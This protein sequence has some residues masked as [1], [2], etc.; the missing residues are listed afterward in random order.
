MNF[1]S[2][3]KFQILIFGLISGLLIGLSYCF[4]F[5]GLL[6]YIG[7]IPLFHS[8]VKRKPKQNILSG[9][10][11]GLVYNLISNYWIAANSGTPQEVALLSLL[12]AVLYLSTFWALAGFIIG[13]YNK[14][15]NVFYILPFLI[16]SLEWI[17]SFGPLGFAWGNISL[18]QISFLPLLQHL[19]IAGTYIVTFWVVS[20]NTLIYYHFFIEKF[21]ILKQTYILCLIILY[22][23]SGWWKMNSFALANYSETID[24]AI[25]QPNIDPNKKWN[26]IGRKQTHQV[27][28]SLYSEAIK[29]NPDIILFPETAL[30]TYIRLNTKVKSLLQSKVDSS[31]IPILIGTVDRRFSIDGVKNF[32]N[33][34]IYFFPGKDIEVYDKIHLVPFAEYDLVPEI[35]HPLVNLNINIER[36]VFK[37][38]SEYKLFN[39]DKVKFS[40]LICY[41]SSFPRYARKFTNIGARFLMIQANDGW[42]GNSRGPYQHFNQS[43]LRSIENRVS[44]ARSGNTGI[45]GIVLPNGKVARKIALNEKSVFNYNIPFDENR[46]FYSAFGDV[47]ATTCFVILLFIGPVVSCVKP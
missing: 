33:S 18:T 39:L 44:I 25:I 11:F 12:L 10:V 40:G 8:W 19:D 46:S 28:D 23:I 7:F 37:G 35:L 14:R 20:I 31:G 45:S 24:V 41:E 21:S 15:Q 36:G 27:M 42:L 17:R 34:S 3:Y 38:G 22:I 29:L 47:F 4:T 5:L 9:Y 1:K 16:V 32:F 43:I 26:K 6:A 2:F 30:P 13:Y